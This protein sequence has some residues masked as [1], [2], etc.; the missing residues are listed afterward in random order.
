MATHTDT[1]QGL[2][3]AATTDTHGGRD[4]AIYTESLVVAVAVA[5]A[6]TAA[7][8]TVVGADEAQRQRGFNLETNLYTFIFHFLCQ[9]FPFQF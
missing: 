7:T 3:S 5:R 9:L 2:M 4:G 8:E 1:L 6:A